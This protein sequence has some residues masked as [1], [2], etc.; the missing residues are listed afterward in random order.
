MEKEAKSVKSEIEAIKQ[1]TWARPTTFDS[2]FADEPNEEAAAATRLERL[3]A[4][5]KSLEAEA[6]SSD[7]EYELSSF[8]LK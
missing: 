8:L 4:E 2:L 7:A 5:L 6:E 3:E 1:G